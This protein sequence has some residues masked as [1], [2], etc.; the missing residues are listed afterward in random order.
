MKL[1]NLMMKR[2]CNICRQAE[3]K[4]NKINW[5][6]RRSMLDSIVSKYKDKGGI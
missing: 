5:E 3:V 4:H 2:V 1:L 6:E